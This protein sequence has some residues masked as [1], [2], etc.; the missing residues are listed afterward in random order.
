MK[1]ERGRG[2]GYARGLLGPGWQL[3]RRILLIVVL[4]GFPVE[5][6]SGER[7]GVEIA[8]DRWQ[9]STTIAID[10]GRT[11]LWAGALARPRFPPFPSLPLVSVACSS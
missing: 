5:I 8:P 7:I 2:R 10:C 4:G 11:H 9:S 6:V 1:K 3:E